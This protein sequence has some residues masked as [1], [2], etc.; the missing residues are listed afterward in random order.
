MSG[1][2]N[3]QGFYTGNRPT[4]DR[5]MD[6]FERSLAVGKREETPGDLLRDA[7]ALIDA[8]VKNGLAFRPEKRRVDTMRHG[9]CGWCK[10]SMGKFR[11]KYCSDGCANKDLARQR[12]LSREKL[13]DKT[14]SEC[15]AKFAA[16][17]NATTCSP[18]CSSVRFKKIRKAS[19]K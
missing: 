13:P 15:G 12:A 4:M 6:K 1:T 14:C 3:G 8:A 10:Q 9:S 19:R 5:L 17:T 16:K 11:K 7:K 2:I 18:E